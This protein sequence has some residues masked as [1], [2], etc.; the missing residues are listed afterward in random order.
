MAKR[1]Q[2]GT[3]APNRP[4]VVPRVQLPTLPTLPAPRVPAPKIAAPRVPAPKVAASHRPA[5]IVSPS[6]YSSAASKTGRD[7]QARPQPLKYTGRAQALNAPKKNA[8][9]ERGNLPNRHG[10]TRNEP[11]RWAGPSAKPLAPTESA[12]AKQTAAADATA[13]RLP[14]APYKPSSPYKPS[15]AGKKTSSTPA[16][17]V[18]VRKVQTKRTNST[19]YRS[20]QA[21]TAARSVSDRAP[22]IAKAID[23]KPIRKSP[24]KPMA[25]N[26]RPSLERPPLRD[27]RNQLAAKP[28][29]EPPVLMPVPNATPGTRNAIVKKPVFGSRNSI[30]ANSVPRPQQ[31]KQTK[32][33]WAN[34][35]P[36]V[37]ARPHYFGPT[38]FPS[39]PNTAKTAGV[40]TEAKPKTS[41]QAPKREISPER[42]IA[43]PKLAKSEAAAPSTPNKAGS[44]RDQLAARNSNARSNSQVAPKSERPRLNA[45][46]RPTV[47]T[48]SIATTSR[49]SAPKQS[50]AR[51]AESFTSKGAAPANTRPFAGPLRTP[52]TT[53]SRNRPLNDSRTAQSRTKPHGF[54]VPLAP[55]ETTRKRESLDRYLQQRLQAAQ[56]HPSNQLVVAQ[57]PPQDPPAAKNNLPT[58][59][60]FEIIDE[61]GRLTV[62]T[63]RSRLLKCKA[64]VFRTAIVD[65]TVVDIVQFTPQEV[66][67]IGKRIGATQVTFWF[68]NNEE[69]P[70]TYLI[71]VHPSTKQQDNRQR[72]YQY[73]EDLIGEIFPDSKI[74]MNLVA[75]KLVVR[76]QAKGAAEA[77]QIMAIIRARSGGNSGGGMGLSGGQ[78]ARVMGPGELG[79][80]T[81]DQLQIINLI[82]IPGVQQVALRVK[83]AELSRSA[84]RGAGIDL[85][86][87]IKINGNEGALLLQS[88]LNSGA[89]ASPALLGQI[90]N[91]EIEIG[92]RWL[93]QHG[94]VRV[95][96]E[97]TLVT[98]SGT[99][100]TFVAGGEFAVPTVVG[101]GG[102]SAVTTDFRAFGAIISFLP[103]V[104]DKDR[105]RLQVSPEFSKIDSALSVGGTPGLQVRSVTTT[106]EMRE[107]QTLAVAGLLDESLTAKRTG[108]L[109]WLEKIVGTRDTARNET[110]L[111]ILVTPELVHPMEPE[112]VPPLPGFDVTEA[113]NKEFYWHGR[114][115]GNPTREYRSTVW[116]TLKRRYGAG[117]SSMIS[118]PFGHGQ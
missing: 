69:E 28:L 73:L 97:P 90:N 93:Q 84:A 9:V 109:P 74:R 89:G 78:V 48:T 24:L 107:G 85:D 62:E 25:R 54:R 104:I 7:T 63:G 79:P 44:Y 43:A 68:E 86:A 61:A 29:P 115:E 76:G 45:S 111:I 117:G 101:T 11:S 6:R 10:S 42:V 66:S 105:I 49:K 2:F 53:V 33:T 81:N 106:V 20:S 17:V 3:P 60:P 87:D 59:A 23:A 58:N 64:G 77:A 83:I 37:A 72:K 99:S 103:T 4:Y 114:I 96:S 40:K 16:Q 30:A 67:I 65:S 50:R 70:Q 75:D 46:P 1:R 5:P 26:E 18:D 82:Q 41:Q 34:A 116:P 21:S 47:P 91:E 102:L 94:I 118:G 14:P 100:A 98:L 110:E 13:K 51:A 57:P 19:P 55:T 31:L 22:R 71:E 38:A 80:E 8:F 39:T 112:E 35:S 27:T 15:L 95:V 56:R 92:F 12:R 113:T 52:A 88:L 32:P 108:N 36:S